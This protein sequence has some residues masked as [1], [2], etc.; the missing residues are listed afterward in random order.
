VCAD[1]S[2]PTVQ[3]HCCVEMEMVNTKTVSIK[4]GEDH[5][6]VGWGRLE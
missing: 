4:S 5:F 2:A 6:D 3:I 1:F